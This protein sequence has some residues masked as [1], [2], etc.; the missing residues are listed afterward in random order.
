VAVKVDEG[1]YPKFQLP[2]L[3][4]RK[5]EAVNRLSL[6]GGEKNR[7]KRVGQV[8]RLETGCAAS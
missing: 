6:L 5:R 7:N 2:T 3:D 4:L 8:G 1:F